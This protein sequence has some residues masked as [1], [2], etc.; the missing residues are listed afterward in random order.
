MRTFD[1]PPLPEIIEACRGR[2]GGLRPSKP[3]KANGLIQFIWR[4]ARFNSG[5]DPCM[6][7]MAYFDLAVW[8]KD[9]APG[10][11]V[12]GIINDEGRQLIDAAEALADKVLEA[13]D[14]DKFGAARRWKGLI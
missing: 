9:H 4:I 8:A 10:A 2:N 13:F 5:H 6:P 12:S 3:R 1:F 14:L 11:E 7:V